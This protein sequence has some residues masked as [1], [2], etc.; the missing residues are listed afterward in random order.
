MLLQEAIDRLQSLSSEV[1]V[2]NKRDRFG[3]NPQNS[4]GIYHKDLDLLA[5]EIGKDDKLALA[6]FETGIYEAKL[7]CSKIYTPKNLTEELMDYFAKGFDTWEICDSF[8]MKLFVKNMWALHKTVE[9]AKEEKLYT[10]RAAFVLMATL[11][12]ADKKAPN[13]VFHVFLPIMIRECTDERLHIKKAISWALRAMGKRNPDLKKRA[14]KT[15]YD[16][17]EIEDSSA[18][19][20]AK[21]VLRE[22]EKEGFKSLLYPREKYLEVP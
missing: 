21:D 18:T 17:L 11:V 9:W 3:I 15:A 13:L 5:K 22:L 6:L 2:K 14:I 20:I 7:L 4:L 8:C 19:W 1:V 10:K 16:M 12:R